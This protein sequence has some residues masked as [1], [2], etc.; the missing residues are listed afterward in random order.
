MFHKYCPSCASL[1]IKKLATGTEECE[2]C[3]FRGNF[4]EGAM[5]E[6]N[7]FKK[8]LKGSIPQSPQGSAAPQSPTAGAVG[9]QAL[10]DKLKS[11]KGKKTDDFEII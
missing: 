3:H 8:S 7:A 1:D 2:R 11:L 6:I 9:S 10:K 5:D 4:K